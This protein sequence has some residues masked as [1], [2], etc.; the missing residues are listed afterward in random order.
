MSGISDCVGPMT[1]RFVAM[2]VIT[3]LALSRRIRTFGSGATSMERRRKL[4]GWTLAMLVLKLS[5]DLERTEH[6]RLRLMP[7]PL[8]GRPDSEKLMT[9]EKVVRSQLLAAVREFVQ[10]SSRLS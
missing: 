2:H 6:N 4:C 1:G 3:V 10:S 9:K 5:K 7:K 8:G